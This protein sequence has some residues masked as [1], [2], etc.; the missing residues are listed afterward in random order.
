MAG[1]GGGGHF[2]QVPQYPA[3]SCHLSRSALLFRRPLRPA[4]SRAGSL[5]SVALQFAEELS[6]AGPQ[7]SDNGG[8]KVFDSESYMADPVCS[9]ARAGYR[10][11]SRRELRSF[12][13]YYATTQNASS[14]SRLLFHMSH[15]RVMA[16]NGA[17]QPWHFWDSRQRRIYNLWKPK[18]VPMFPVSAT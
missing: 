5:S 2:V 13:F 10:L 8:I 4:G 11:D 16:C 3:I 17:W 7:A 1:A 6:T 14:C 15:P 12:F 18:E 9:P